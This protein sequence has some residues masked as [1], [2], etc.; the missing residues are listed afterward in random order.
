M[1]FV[2]ICV[3][4][5]EERPTPEQKKE[6]ISGVTKLVGE[7]L[8]K[9]TSNMVVIIDEI[10]MENYGIGGGETVRERRKEHQK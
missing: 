9:N 10:P 8:G 1:P 2:R 4:G 7:V 5:D 3:T 6:L